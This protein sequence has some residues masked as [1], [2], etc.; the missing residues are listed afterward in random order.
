MHG[1]NGGTAQTDSAVPAPSASSSKQGSLETSGREDEEMEV[2]RWEIITHRPRSVPTLAS[3]P[4]R[5]LLLV[6]TENLHPSSSCVLPLCR[7]QG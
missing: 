3:H 1:K 7:D 5:L 2:G 6:V 4:A